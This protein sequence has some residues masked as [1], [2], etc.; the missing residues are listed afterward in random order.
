VRPTLASA[1]LRSSLFREILR[2]GAP[3]SVNTVFTNLTVVLLTALVAPLG[4]TA[5][6]GYG[7]GARL[8]YLQLPLV[9]G[10]GSGLVTMVGAN[11]GAGH[12]E[13]A[14][15][16][17]WVGASFAA[18]A[19][20]SLGLLAALFPRAWLGLFTK[21]PE[22]IAA[23]T[24]YLTTVGPLY[25]FFGLGLALYFGCQGAGNLRWPLVAGFGRAA[26]AAFGGWLA[27]RAFDGGLRGLCLAIALSFLLYGL[28]M[29]AA[30]RSGALRRSP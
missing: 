9:F 14:E 22:V 11:T 19:T 13:R 21:D 16:V 12:V 24:T 25:A 5:L 26:T 23:G 4:P 30:V 18:A 1:G 2:V 6:A 17:A 29:A 7:L 8:E 15:R 27:I 10:L 28:A 3:G 20:G